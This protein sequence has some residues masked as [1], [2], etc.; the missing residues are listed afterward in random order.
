MSLQMGYVYPALYLV[1]QFAQ[2]NILNDYYL[3][4]S[5]LDEDVMRWFKR[6][7][8]AGLIDG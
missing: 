8:Y 3:P 2:F 1:V 5:S 7:F 4:V 6:L